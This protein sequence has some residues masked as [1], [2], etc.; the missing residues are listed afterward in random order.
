LKMNL[1][2]NGMNLESKRLRLKEFDW[3]DLEDVH[4]IHSI[5]EVDEFN[6]LGLPKDLAET[7]EVMREFIEGRDAQPRK[8]YAWV[9]KT[10]DT[11]QTI[12]LTGMI[13]SAD[14]FRL[15]EI[16]YKLDPAFWYN[17]YA[18]E[19]AKTLVSAGIKIFNLHK[20]E[21]GV[22]IGNER[23]IRV[24][25]KAGMLREGLRRKILP[26][27]GQWVDAYHYAIVE[28]EWRE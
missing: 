14:R 25:E 9:I 4:R 23:S 17:G 12:G 10:R 26:I 15:G 22:A 16:F 2:K 5:P 28:D 13:L 27:R 3:D 6:T 7:R 11:E 24:L 21:A 1:T 20:V 8:F 19:T 18:T